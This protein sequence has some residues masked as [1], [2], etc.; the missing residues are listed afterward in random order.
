MLDVVITLRMVG[1][2]DQARSKG[3]SISIMA[4]KRDAAK[5]AA[6]LSLAVSVAAAGLL[7]ARGHRLSPGR[8]RL[9]QHEYLLHLLQDLHVAF[10]YP[11]RIVTHL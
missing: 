3:A 10:P 4:F 6:P 11:A 9:R 8:Q 7:K 5:S 2:A 1:Y